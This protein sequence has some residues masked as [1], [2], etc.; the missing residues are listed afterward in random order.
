MIEDSRKQVCRMYESYDIL[1]IK[2]KAGIVSASKELQF[3]EIHKELIP[4]KGLQN[5]SIYMVVTEEMKTKLMSI[6]NLYAQISREKKIKDI[7]LL[8]AFHSATIEGART[9][10]ENVRKAYDKPKTKDDKMV[11]NTIYGMNYAYANP[12]SMKNIRQLWE[13]VTKDVCDNSHLAGELFRK[14]MVYVG[15]N[16]DIIHTPANPEKIEEM[17]QELF[18]FM[19][20]SGLNI[21][22]KAAISH[23]YFVYIH[24]FCDGNGRTVRIMTQAFLKHGGMEKIQYL[25]LSRAINDNL[26]GYY[27]SLKESEIVYKNEERWMDITSFIDYML[28]VIEK[29]ML[30]ALKEDNELAEKQKL[31]LSKMQ[32]RGIGAEITLENATGILKVSTQ[33][34]GEYLN[35]LVEMGYLEYVEKERKSIYRLK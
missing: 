12:I 1:R 11:I 30:T 29:C 17:M 9:T 15:S 24:P 33:E 22:I 19:E 23:F 6:H 14:G 26:S 2:E 13:I 21:W 7:I 16:T 5:T 4:L 35:E 34:A 8:D 20:T 31:L 18:R 32:K 3:R 27:N 28:N 10:V 25:S